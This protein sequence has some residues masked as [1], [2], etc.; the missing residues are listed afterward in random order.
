MKGKDLSTFSCELLVS[1]PVLSNLKTGNST[2]LNVVIGLHHL[3]NKAEIFAITSDFNFHCYTINA[4]EKS[5]N[6]SKNGEAPLAESRQFIGFNDDILDI[7]WIPSPSSSN[8]FL[9]ED[10]EEIKIVQV[11]KLSLAVIT[12]STQ[13]KLMDEN[14]TCRLMSGHEDI[15]LAADVSSDV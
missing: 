3:P 9:D 5:P 12:K 15:V 13:I 10:S 8:T 1:I 2:V 6:S 7:I 4:N 11:P 14:F